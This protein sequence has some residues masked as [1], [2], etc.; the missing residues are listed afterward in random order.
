MTRRDEM[1]FELGMFVLS[2][3]QEDKRFHLNMALKAPYP[4]IT[5][6]HMKDA[7]EVQTELGKAIEKVQR[8][9]RGIVPSEPE[10]EAVPKPDLRSRSDLKEQESPSPRKDYELSEAQKKSLI[11]VYDL[12]N[13]HENFFAAGLLY[14]NFPDAFLQEKDG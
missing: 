9:L 4:Q 12:L 10:P 3:M 6:R 14:S 8:K 2:T 11:I 13:K 1:E 5:D 7:S